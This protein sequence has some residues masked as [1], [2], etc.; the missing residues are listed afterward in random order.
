MSEKIISSN[1]NSFLINHNKNN[2]NKNYNLILS[3]NTNNNINIKNNINNNNN[4]NINQDFNNNNN[5]DYFSINNN[6]FNP[7]TFNWYLEKMERD[8]KVEKEKLKSEIENFSNDLKMKENNY[9]IGNDLKKSTEILFDFNENSHSF[10]NILIKRIG[11]Q[12]V[13]ISQL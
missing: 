3:D 7:N 9:I 13:K 4:I 2:S 11:I 8:Q 5:M 12:D 10:K 6:S 1:K